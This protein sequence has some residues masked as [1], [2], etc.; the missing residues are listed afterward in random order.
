[1]QVYPRGYPSETVRP[2]TCTGFALIGMCGK[3]ARPRVQHR[4]LAVGGS[5]GGSALAREPPGRA[6][7][8]GRQPMSVAP[9]VTA[10]VPSTD[11]FNSPTE[12]DQAD[13]LLMLSETGPLARPGG[14]LPP[15]SPRDDLLM[16]SHESK[17]EM[18]ELTFAHLPRQADG[19]EGA[20]TP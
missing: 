2:L 17:L 10:V 20:L 12:S 13:R 11:S 7:H 3:G 14:I 8:H 18:A 1:M 5:S 9:A 19:R 4:M 6:G 15:G 16:T